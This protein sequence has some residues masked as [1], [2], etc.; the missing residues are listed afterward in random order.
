MTDDAKT[1]AGRRARPL[2]SCLQP[3]LKGLRSDVSYSVGHDAEIVAE[4]DFR[5]TL[6]RVPVT[7][8]DGT[9]YRHLLIV[10]TSVGA[11]SF[12]VGMALLEEQSIEVDAGDLDTVERIAEALRT[13]YPSL[14]AFPPPTRLNRFFV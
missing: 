12:D 4:E 9:G 8:S 10:P 5:Y 11:A 3:Y 13:R 2:R 7:A 14:T 1:T 6:Y